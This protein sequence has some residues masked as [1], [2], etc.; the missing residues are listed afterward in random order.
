MT[1]T[2]KRIHYFSFLFLVLNTGCTAQEPLS[3]I[4]E[5]PKN[6]HW[7][8]TV[9]LIQPRTMDEVATG[10]TGQVIDSAAVQQ[11]GSFA[12]DNMPEVSAPTLFELAVQKKGERFLNRLENDDPVT[13]NYFPIVWENG[14]NINITADIKQFQ[15]SFSIRNPSPANGELLKLRDIRLEAFRQFLDKDPFES[16]DAE[17]LMDEEA[18]LLNFQKQLIH[19]ANS[20]NYFLPAITAIR[21]VSPGNDYER[22][23]EFLV[24]QCE[25]WQK[26]VPDHPWVNQLCSKGN[27]DQ[28]PVLVGDQVPDTP[29]PMASGDTTNLHALLGS[30]LTVLDMWAS[31]CAP[32]RKENRNILVPLWDSYHEKGFQVIAYGLEASEGAWKN[33]IEKDGTAR[34]PNASHLMGDDAPFMEKLRI[35][36]IPANFILDADGKVI[37]KNIHGQELV[38]FV[39][40]YLKK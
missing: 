27:R 21:W 31:W 38:E 37:A 39:E 29:L 2:M 33:A 8:T 1:Q 6:D 5:L 16:H 26:T 14:G 36:T 32:C 19:F 23:P 13:A 4:M 10:F 7:A 3:G 17:Q 30:R 11:D 28:L 25:K 40:E 9:Y 22:V 20:T 18:A 35:Q 24:S 15:S 12:F 34:W